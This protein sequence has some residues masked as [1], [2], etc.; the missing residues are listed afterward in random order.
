[1]IVWKI[2]SGTAITNRKDLRI[3]GSAEMKPHLWRI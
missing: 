1:M 3:K 2:V